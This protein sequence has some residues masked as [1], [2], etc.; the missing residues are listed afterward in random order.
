VSAPLSMDGVPASRLRPL[1]GAP[2]RAKAGHVLYWMTSARRP[3][4]NFAL[5]RAAALARARDLPLVVLEGLR[6]DHPWAAAR[7]HAFCLA[8]MAEHREVFTK[9]GVLHHAWVEPAPGASRG[10]LEAWAADAHVVVTDDSPAFFLPRMARAAAARLGVRV[11]AVDGVGLLPLSA[12]DRPFARAVDFRRHLHKTLPAH[13]GALPDADPLPGLRPHAGPAAPL[14]RW[15]Q[16]DPALLAG[17]PARLAALPIDAAVPPS[18]LQGGPAEAQRR[19]ARFLAARLGGYAEDRNH[20]GRAGG[21]GLSPWLHWGHIGVHQ[22]FAELCA[23]EGWTPARLA[24]K[25]TASREGWW[26]MSPAAESLIDELITWRELGQHFCHHVPDHDR[27]DGLPEWARG[28]LAEH[29]ADPRPRRYTLAQ[30]EA[31]ATHDPVW[32]AAQRQ[33]LR[34]G[35]MHN[36][37]RMLWGK[38]VLEW[39]DSPA[40][41]WDRLF[42]LNNKHALDGRD[43]NSSTGIAWVFGRFD[44]A[45]GPERPIYGKIRY[46]T[47]ENTVKKLEMGD[48][49][50][51]YA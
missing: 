26:G 7:H 3:Q 40:Q 17:D 31:A 8:G 19:W 32:N 6:C 47:S 20:P 46:M 12:S 22:L 49:L 9:A 23:A 42:H 11:E 38:K 51:R 33:L 25:P 30:L 50:R 43:P 41:A 16:A 28:T 21:T 48:Y 5:Q 15:P 24:P 14:A 35:V 36:Y 2:P 34:E 29:A 18:P 1:N 44:R 27:Y 37:L 10:L 4:W 45:W 39:S 13:L